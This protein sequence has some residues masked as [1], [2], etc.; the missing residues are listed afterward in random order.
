MKKISVMLPTYNEEKNVREI[1]QAI[2]NVFIKDLPDYD[3]EILFIDN[4]SRDL[5]RSILRQICS[6]DKHVKA[7]FNIANFGQFNSPFY[8]MC[9]CTGDCVVSM[10]SDFQDP[11]EYIPQMVKA[12]EKGN[13]VICMIKTSS[14]ENPIMYFFRSCYYYLIKKM[15]NIEQISHFTG[16]GLYDISFVKILAKLNDSTP[17][18]KGIIS[19][20][21]P[22]HVE[23]L[24]VQQKRKAGKSKNNF[25]SLYDYAMLSFTSYTK[26]GLR[27]ATFVGI[28]ISALSFI[29]SM[30]YLV[31][32]LLMWD[33]FIAGNAPA[34][35][36]SFFLGG[37]Q[38]IFLG[39]LGEYVMSMNTR[40]INKPLVVEEERLNFETPDDVISLSNDKL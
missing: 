25:F 18:I 26:G 22:D 13:K 21:A 36:G 1:Y 3:Y 32:K 38:L 2:K 15:S 29:L 16:F 6:E 14:K 40:V 35:I 27:I 19:E 12:W 34:L 11:P 7:I 31:M 28:L 37:I 23:I 10:C 9:Q 8:A 39:L 17:Y 5:T 20:Y 30:I 4:K 33:E 24:Y